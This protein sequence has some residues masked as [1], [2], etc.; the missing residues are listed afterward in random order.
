MGNRLT[1]I[2]TRTG[3]E[4]TTGLADG[5][6][7]NKHDIQIESIGVIDELNSAIGF[8]LCQK[9][10]DERLKDTLVGIQHSLFDTGAELSLPDYVAIKPENVELLEKEIDRL[11]ESLPPLR[12]FILPGGNASAAACHMARASARRAERTLW[13]RAQT[14]HTAEPLLKF[15]NRL[16]DFLFVAARTLARQNGGSEVFWQSEHSRKDASL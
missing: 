3:D 8:L 14:C 4:G 10:K 7:V 2:Y 5:S 16:S 13:Q 9:I 12:E 11:N 15:L 1:K 6:R